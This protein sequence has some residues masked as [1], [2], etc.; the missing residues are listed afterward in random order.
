MPTA[1]SRTLATLSTLCLLAVFGPA[2]HLIAQCATI[3]YPSQL[4]RSSYTI[5]WS[6]AVFGRSVDMDGAL[7]VVGSQGRAEVF[8]LSDNVWIHEQTLTPPDD[9]HGG[10]GTAVA[11]E[12]SRIVVSDA[13]HNGDEGAFYVF[14]RVGRSWTP[15]P[16]N[17]VLLQRHPPQ[18]GARFGVSIDVSGNRIIVGAPGYDN[19]ST[20]GVAFHFVPDSRRGWVE[21][22][23]IPSSGHFNRSVPTGF[24]HSVAIDGDIIA[25]GMPSGL[26]DPVGAPGRNFTGRVSIH[27]KDNGFRS[28][29]TLQAKDPTDGD[30]FGF[31]VAVHA[32]RIVVGAP[33]RAQPAL[34]IGSVATTRP[35]YRSGG[36]YVFD[37]QALGRYGQ[38]AI[39]APDEYCTGG[40]TTAFGSAVAVFGGGIVVGAPGA[41][42]VQGSGEAYLYEQ[43]SSRWIE[44]SFL[45]Y[46]AAGRFDNAGK[47][48]AFNGEFVAVGAPFYDRYAG[49]NMMYS[50]KP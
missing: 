13:G 31:A 6:G 19:G 42:G 10:F 28:S 27:E 17:P 12:G 47:A 21:G 48:V 16:N 26:L 33:E 3:N 15:D 8:R 1:R 14:N 37:R 24:G 46:R 30:R 29:G 38:T 39:L 2:P 23:L 9:V 32:G 35:A 11:V 44:R 49:L 4:L 25:I 20:L 45:T 50:A 40:Y 5:P 7:M 41:R 34:G 43:T 36:V 22:I 18:A